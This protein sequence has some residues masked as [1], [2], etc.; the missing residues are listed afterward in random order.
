MV[1][2]P[3]EHSQWMSSVPCPY[4]TVFILFVH[5]RERWYARPVVRYVVMV[6]DIIYEGLSL[7]GKLRT[8]ARVGLG[9]IFCYVGV[10][11]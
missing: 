1:Q 6:D 2:D 7:V 10:M 11:T 8:S 3:P 4:P 9:I 5:L